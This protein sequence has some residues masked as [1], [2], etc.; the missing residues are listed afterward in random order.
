MISTAKSILDNE[1]CNEVPH[2]TTA[3]DG[4]PVRAGSSRTRHKFAAFV[5]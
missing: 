2:L 4:T 3:A 1:I 5:A